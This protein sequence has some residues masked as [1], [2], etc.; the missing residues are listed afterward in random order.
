MVTYFENL[1]IELHILYVLTTY[2]KFHANQM[3]FIIQSTN[4][5]FMHNF[6]LQNLKVVFG[7]QHLD[8]D[9]DLKSIDLKCLYLKSLNFKIPCL[10]LFK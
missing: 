3:Q 9:W 2:V 10:N 7:W 1:V 6:R 8:L 4:L 5:F